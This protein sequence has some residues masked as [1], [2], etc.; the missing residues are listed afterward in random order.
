MRSSVALRIGIT[1]TQATP[2]TAPA[3]V[4]GLL[5]TM[6]NAITQWDSDLTRERLCLWQADVLRRNIWQADIFRHDNYA[7]LKG[8]SIGQYRRHD[9]PMQV[10]SGLEE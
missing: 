6:E 2:A 10:V 7:A 5:D 9:A 4:E 8:I 1:S 3:A